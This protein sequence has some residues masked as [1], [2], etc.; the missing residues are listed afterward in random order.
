VCVCAYTCVLTLTVLLSWRKVP[1]FQS[2]GCCYWWEINSWGNSS[3]MKRILVRWLSGGWTPKRW[4]CSGRWPLR[5]EGVGESLRP[6]ASMIV[7]GWPCPF[8]IIPWHLLYNWSKARKTA[9]RLA[10]LLQATRCADLALLWGTASAGLLHV[11][12]PRS[13]VG[14][15]SQPSVG[16]SAFQVA[17]QRGSLRQLTSILFR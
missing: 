16:T 14:D 11:S 17:K 8:W 2:K 9:V 10:P 15:F 7:G 13:P 4:D 6:K 3:F 1:T 5:L 12:L